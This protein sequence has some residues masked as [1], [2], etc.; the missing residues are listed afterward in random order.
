MPASTLERLPRSS[1]ACGCSRPTACRSWASCGSKSRDD[2]SLW[3]R[4]GGEGYETK[5]VDGVLW[6]RAETA[7]LG[8]LNAASPFD[9]EGWFNTQDAVEQDGDW[10][11]FLGR[12]TDL[13]NVGG[14]KVYP[15]EVESVLL[16]MDNVARRR[17]SAASPTRSSASAS[18]RGSTSA[19]PRRRPTSRPGCGGTARGRLAPYM[20]PVKVEI[21]AVEQFGARCK[22]LR[23]SRPPNLAPLRDAHRNVLPALKCGSF[24]ADLAGVPARVIDRH[25]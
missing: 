7:M 17:R 2:G 11:R 21:A 13:I 16:E 4:V 22:R 24:A 19:S 1:P 15:A 12:T 10:L 14:Q 23:G 3:V 18:W 5:V 9:A 25:F 20:I 8:Y 6:I